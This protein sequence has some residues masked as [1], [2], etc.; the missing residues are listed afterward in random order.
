LGVST[1]EY[2]T[3]DYSDVTVSWMIPYIMEAKKLGIISGQ[4]IV[5][6]KTKK[7]VAIFRPND[8]ITRAEA[9]K[10]LLKAKGIEIPTVLN[11]SFTDIKETWMISYAEKAKELGI[12]D[13]QTVD[14]KLIFRPNYPITRAESS[15]IIVNMMEQ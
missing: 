1:D 15:K 3:T 13:G 10:I 12:I 5:N 8:S 7:S 4:E 6:K 2:A 14:D 11:S 9:I